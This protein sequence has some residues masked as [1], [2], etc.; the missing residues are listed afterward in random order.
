[1]KTVVGTM[2]VVKDE[3]VELTNQITKYIESKEV[4][5]TEY[6]KALLM[7]ELKRIAG[8]ID[9]ITA[10]HI[11]KLDREINADQRIVGDLEIIISDIKGLKELGI[12]K[13]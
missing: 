3:F 9:R 12:L 7:S 5:H 8:A 6:N 4:G 13:Y 10:P 1:M 2:E 11:G